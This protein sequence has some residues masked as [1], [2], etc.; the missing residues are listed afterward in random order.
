MIK[1]GDRVDERFRITS[2][3]A[4]GGMSDIYEASDLVS[5]RVVC[6]K[7]M[8]EE[9]CRDNENM[10]RF[11]NE[12]EASASLNN[13]NII[14]VYGKG[15]ID[16]RPYMACEYIKAQTLREKL[17]FNMAFSLNE[18][19]EIMLQ[20][21]DGLS[22]IHQH[23][24][25]HRDIKPDNLYLLPDGTLKIADFGIAS[26]IGEKAK[27]QEAIRGTIYYTAP[28]ILLGQTALVSSDI[29]SMGI[30]FFELLTGAI[31]FDGK[32]PEDVALKQIK[33]KFP[34][35]SKFN[36]SVPKVI[37]RIVITACRKEP[38]ERYQSASAMHDAILLAM[39]DEAHFKE[40]R[41]IF[42]KI[43]GLK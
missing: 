33:N 8:K 12:V 19:C 4:S 21:S 13:P 16:G 7:V 5:K 6:L 10:K 20:L 24:I 25:L 17:K 39:S 22:Y 43:F 29:Y 30:V 1:I 41:G 18:A 38:K 26:P 23:G 34:E 3:V 36:P 32:S 31:P 2:R 37:D 35:P 28:E 40:K 9:L 14:R 42:S 15:V 11:E 27:P